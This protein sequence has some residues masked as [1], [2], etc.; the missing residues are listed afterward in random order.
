M[1]THNEESNYKLARLIDEKGLKRD[2]PRIFFA[3]LLGMSDNISFNLAH[4]GY[5]VTKYV[6]YARVRDV[7]PYLIRRAEENTSVAGQTSRE[8]RMLKAELDSLTTQNNKLIQDQGEYQ[9]LKELYNLDQTYEDY[10]KVAATI[11]SKDPGNWYETFMINKGS[12]DG[13]R[14]DN[15]V[16]AGKG[17]VGI[18]TEVGSSWAT[19]RSIIDDS[20]SVS[21]MT[22][23]TSDNCIVNGDLELIDEGKLRF[24]QL[25]DQENKVTVGERIVTSNISEKFVEGLFI[26]YV[27][28]VQVDSNNLTKTGTIV[29][30]VDFLHLK[31]V[32]VITV[33]KQDL[34]DGTAQVEGNSDSGSSDSTSGDS[35]QESS[36]NTDGSAADGQ[37]GADEG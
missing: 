14:V 26:G 24:E 27:S 28:G 35:S 9:R 15:N 36:D 18:V 13:I 11:I 34:V 23:S 17:L 19:V 30:P 8:L 3:Q 20:S 5:N 25:Y 2:D 29:T 22:V 4:E 6:P 21:A 1:G 32:F 7:L 37:E 10:P 16:I 31:D 33:N 12:D